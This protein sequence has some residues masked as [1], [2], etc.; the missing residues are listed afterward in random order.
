M[1]TPQE[2]KRAITHMT[3]AAAAH[4]RRGD[5]NNVAFCVALADALRWVEGQPS[6]FEET[7]R[8]CDRLDRLA[9]GTPS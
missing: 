5:S 1:R 8:R 6:E 7:L 2:I 4:E 3:E 9:G